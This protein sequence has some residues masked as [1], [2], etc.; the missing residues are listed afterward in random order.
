MRDWRSRTG[1]PA[2]MERLPNQ[3]DTKGYGSYVIFGRAE[4]VSYPD[5]ISMAHEA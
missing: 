4:C 1:H 3:V 2:G 5:G